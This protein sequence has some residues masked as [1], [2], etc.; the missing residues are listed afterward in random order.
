MKIVKMTET[1]ANEIIKWEYT[2]PYNIYNMPD[3]YDELLDSYLAIEEHSL[4]GF[5]CF[6]SDAQVPPGD[7]T[8]DALD[9]GLGMKPI[10]CGQGKGKR[11]FGKIETFA[12]ETYKKP[13]RLTVAG[14]NKRAIKLYNQCGFK[15]ISRF[16]KNEQ[17]FI[18]MMQ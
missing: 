16:Y 15:E 6:G 13:L 9:F 12:K 10:L 18:I 17:L 8:I 3:T 1:Y 14:F 4:V 5:C 7:Y 11:F 2:S